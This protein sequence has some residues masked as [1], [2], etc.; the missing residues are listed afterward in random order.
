MALQSLY[1]QLWER[2]RKTDE[3]QVKSQMLTDTEK[4][5]LLMAN[6]TMS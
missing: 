1:S 6:Y 4:T 2:D 3:F 5:P